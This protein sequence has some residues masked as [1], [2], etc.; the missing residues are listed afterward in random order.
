MDLE[1]EAKFKAA[2]VPAEPPKAGEVVEGEVSPPDGTAE[3]PGPSGAE[4]A[5]V[6]VAA[7][8]VAVAVKEEEEGTAAEAAGGRQAQTDKKPAAPREGGADEDEDD[9]D[10]DAVH[11]AK[12]LRVEPARDKKDKKQKVDEDEIQ[13]MQTHP[14]MQQTDQYL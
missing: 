2:A 12:R 4:S 7:A 13:K 1:Q 11:Q 9:E 6:V 14:S 10:G 3:Q 5:V 8:A